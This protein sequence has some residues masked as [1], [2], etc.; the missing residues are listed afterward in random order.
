MGQQNSRT[1]SQ[2]EEDRQ[3]AKEHGEE[4]GSE[5][6]EEERK[7]IDV[8]GETPRGETVEV[9]RVRGALPPT[10]ENADLPDF[11]PECAHLLLGGSLWRLPPP[12]Q[13][14]APG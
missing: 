1:P 7:G 8:E 12:Q 2:R 11:A 5:E 14:V 13:W 4:T 3:E 6:E 9:I 10:E